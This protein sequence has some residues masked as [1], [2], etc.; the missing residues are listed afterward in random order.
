MKTLLSIIA[1]S[2]ILT[3]IWNMT[4]PI[5]G[6]PLFSL[7][8]SCLVGALAY[9]IGRALGALGRKYPALAGL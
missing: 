5:T 1:R 9:A 3:I 8:I 7:G 4:T 2:T 6:L